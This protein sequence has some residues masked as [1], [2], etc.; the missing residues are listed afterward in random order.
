MVISCGLSDFGQS[1]LHL[2]ILGAAIPLA[3]KHHTGCT[4]LKQTRRKKY[5]KIYLS[6]SK[7][8]RRED[9]LSGFLQG[10]S[11]LP[12]PVLSLSLT[13]MSLVWVLRPLPGP[14]GLLRVPG[15]HT[16]PVV[17]RRR[18]ALHLWG[19][20][21]AHGGEGEGSSPGRVLREFW[22]IIPNHP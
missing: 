9:Q 2:Q 11:D 3:V 10:T 21:F 1:F 20:P 14:Q 17:P 18:N 4:K 8:I 13:R 7:I 19:F 15:V 12:L 6:H 22:F 5:K 16:V